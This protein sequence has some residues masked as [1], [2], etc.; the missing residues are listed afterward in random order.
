MK[1]STVNSQEHINS[2]KESKKKISFTFHHE[3]STTL[4]MKYLLLICPF[5]F[6]LYTFSQS[7]IFSEDFEQTVGLQTSQHLNQFVIESCAGNGPSNPGTKAA[8]IAPRVP[9][10]DC[11]VYSSIF[12][13]VH[14]A[15]NQEEISVFFDVQAGCSNNL[16]LRFDYKR[17]A[18]NNQSAYIK[19]RFLNT[20]WY[21]LIPLPNTTGWSSQYLALPSYLSNTNF[22][23][24]FSY[25]AQDASNEIE[26]LA[27]DN[28][29][30][31]GNDNQAPVIS[32]PVGVEYNYSA[33][34]TPILPDLTNEI[35]ILNPCSTPYSITQSFP[36]GATVPPVF[37]VTLTL[38]TLS[39]FTTSCI[40][41]AVAKDQVGPILTCPNNQT[42]G[43][44]EN[45]E[46]VLPDFRSQVTISENCTPISD[47]IVHQS[48]P[49]GTITSNSVINLTMSATDAAGNPGIC[50]FS[51]ELKD[52]APPTIVN[53]PP[54]KTIYANTS[55][56]QTV[57]NM[58]NEVSFTDNCTQPDFIFLQ[59]SPPVNSPFGNTTQI[60]VEAEDE[61]GNRN[62]CVISTVLVDT[63]APL[64]NCQQPISIVNIDACTFQTPDLSLQLTY[65]DNCTPNSQLLFTQ[66]SNYAPGLPCSEQIDI[67]V[68]VTDLNGNEK[69]CVFTL[70][71]TDQIPPTISCPP[72]TNVNANTQCEINLSNYTGQSTVNDNCGINTNRF[73]QT[74]LP[75]TILPVGTHPITLTTYDYAGNSNNCTFELH[76][77][78][79][80]TPTI[81]CP[82]NI[83]QCDPLVNYT[84][85]ITNSSCGE[86]I[87]LL[88]THGLT[89]GM[90]FP[91]GETEMHYQVQNNNG[92]SAECRFI[93]H[94]LNENE[95]AK[96]S[97]S[98]LS[99]CGT[100]AANIEAITPQSGVGNW[101]V[102]QGSA[103]LSSGTN[104]STTVSNLSIGSNVFVWSVT[105]PICGTFHDTLRIQYGTT[106][107][108]SIAQDS[109]FACTQNYFNVNAVTNALTGLW[110]SNTS[111]TF[112]NPSLPNTI[113][114]QLSFGWNTLYFTANQ[115][116]C[117][118]ITDSILVFRSGNY[119]MYT[120]EEN[121]CFDQEL[122]IKQPIPNHKDITSS[123]WSGSPH[124]LF[125][126]EGNEALISGFKTGANE[127]SLIMEYKHCPNTKQ[128]V[129]VNVISCA[130]DLA[131]EL[132]NLI[133]PNYDGKND[134]FDLNGLEIQ[135]TNLSLH[136]F[137]RWGSVV[138]QAEGEHA[139]WRATQTNGD[140]VPPG[141]YFYHIQLNDSNNEIIKGSITVIY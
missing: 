49:P 77:I 113:A 107:Q 86:T 120:L 55:C 22:Q 58:L 94:I 108:L 18:Q 74:P 138:F 10:S 38:T 71:P 141:V 25:I 137:D 112:V 99:L 83:S 44:N 69:A 35:S 140:L 36:A 19:Y 134:Y 28:I 47:I 72:S 82:A 96:I 7:V 20:P 98:D 85:P 14:T 110:S 124:L 123:K 33:L 103:S 45:C 117:T 95:I 32:C 78:Q 42:I 130:E 109:A 40:I 91:I 43:R 64:M 5:I 92:Q 135:Y 50:Q 24:Q 39:G 132:P 66:T 46:A 51:I 88:S 70:A 115:P 61:T 102:I 101:T 122:T 84:A 125:N 48:I 81:Q 54:V 34:C 21:E 133:T 121:Y 9:L 119:Q 114:T 11:G 90:S 16:I 13:G 4:R 2:L 23:L 80:N 65:T 100:N 30:V 1:L 104:P 111:A 97:T 105:H 27:I 26:P 128:S 76:V 118:S 87:T 17:I 59:Q 67:T 139:L 31:M 79:T 37:D 6:G 41:R 53:C 93:I 131:N 136:I 116:G 12:N 62:T 89:S 60:T 57:P 129:L 3:N 52:L 126:T 127:I 68:T 73:T 106:P 75:G 56:T 63:I 29:V 8:Y 15:T